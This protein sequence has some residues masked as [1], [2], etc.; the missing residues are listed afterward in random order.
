LRLT[1]TVIAAALGLALV[2]GGG[3]Q[4]LSLA[5]RDTF[6]ARASYTGVRSLVVADDTGGVRITEA[7]AGSPV[8]VIEHVTRALSSPSRRA[9]RGAGGALALTARCRGLFN[10]ECGVD[11]EIAVPSGTRVLIQSS[12][13]D[14]IVRDFVTSQPV[15]LSSSA[16]DVRADGIRAPSV[17]LSSSAGDVRAD[18]IRTPNLRLSSSAGDVN[19]RQI[20]SSFIQADSSA[21][22]VRL[23]AAVAPRRV[24][25]TS[26]AGDV[27]LTVPDAVYA[28]DVTTVDGDKPDVS[29]RQDPASPRRISAESTAGN[30][31]IHAAP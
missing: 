23:Q 18:R 13:G 12:A 7:P 22:D 8:R 1:L 10:S 9:V 11:Y 6:D 2:T 25:A 14:V 24:I 19:A 4:L 29:V 5:A 26:T 3:Y 21:G 27:A 30:V 28:V 16:G 31:S 20:V 15:S 17:R